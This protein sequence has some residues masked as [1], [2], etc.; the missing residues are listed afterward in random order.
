MILFIA[1]FRNRNNKWYFM[2]NYQKVSED[3]ISQV[4]TVEKRKA[5]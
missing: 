1:M 4:I 3:V 2:A 5:L